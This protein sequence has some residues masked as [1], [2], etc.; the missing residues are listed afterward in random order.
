MNVSLNPSD[1]RIGIIRR[2]GIIEYSNQDN[3]NSSNQSTLG[4]INR[5]FQNTID[6]IIIPKANASSIFL[7]LNA[8]AS[9]SIEYHNQNLMAWEPFLEPLDWTI[10]FEAP[11]VTN[12]SDEPVIWNLEGIAF[13]SDHLVLNLLRND[14]DESTSATP[15]DRSAKLR[16]NFRAIN[17]NVTVSLLESLRLTIK[18]L[19]KLNS[20]NVERRSRLKERILSPVNEDDTTDL[21]MMIIRN[22]SGLMMRYWCSDVA[23]ATDI[24]PNTEK[25]LHMDI[26]GNG[27]IIKER[28]FDP[29]STSRSV[30]LSLQR[31]GGEPWPTLRD[32]PLDG[33]GCRL[34]LLEM[35]DYEGSS[36][37]PKK[38][39]IGR[40]L[41]SPSYTMLASHNSVCIAAELISRGGVRT[42][43]IRSTIRLNNSTQI[44]LH[45]QLVSGAPQR[46]ILWDAVI[47]ACSEMSVPANYCSIS[48]GRFF[49]QPLLEFAPSYSRGKRASSANSSS[50]LIPT[51]M[52]IPKIPGQVI[53]GARSDA[54]F[55][56]DQVMNESELILESQSTEEFLKNPG[57]NTLKWRRKLLQK[58]GTVDALS[59]SH[60]LIFNKHPEN[61]NGDSVARISCNVDILSQGAPRTSSTRNSDSFMLRTLTFTPPVTI[62][63]LLRSDVE[64]ALFNGHESASLINLNNNSYGFPVGT[65]V[66]PLHPGE[67]YGCVA[68]HALEKVNLSI[69]INNASKDYVWSNIVII[70]A[71][72]KDQSDDTTLAADIK[73][74]NGSVLTVLL[75][76]IDQKGH[77]VINLYVPFWIVSSSFIT[78]QY[79][80]DSRQASEKNA[81]IINGLDGLAAD[82]LF[83]EKR[84][85]KDG[86]GPLNFRKAPLRGIGKSRGVQGIVLGPELPVRGLADILVSNRPSEF[87][88]LITK[89]ADEFSVYSNVEG[90]SETY[91]SGI[92]LPSHYHLIQCSYT[93]FDRRSGRLRL[94]GSGTNWS[95]FFSLDASNST[96]VEIETSKKYA[97]PEDNNIAGRIPTNKAGAQVFCFGIFT[98]VADPPF[99]RTRVTIVV[100]RYILLNSMGQSLE[101]RQF[102]NEDVTTVHPNDQCPFWW[103]PGNQLIQIRL[104]RYGWAWS[105]RF[106]LKR[107]GEIPLRLR[108]EH[109]N[110][111]FFV[112]VHV[113][114]QG[115]R[116][117]IVF[118]GGDSVAP[119]RI[120][121]HTLETFKLRQVTKKGWRQDVNLQPKQTSL[122]PYHTCAYAWDEPLA[123]QE[124]VLELL[125]NG[126]SRSELVGTFSFNRLE[127]FPLKNNLLIR[128]IAQGPTR[129][130]CIHD[131]RIS[132]NSTITNKVEPDAVKPELFKLYMNVA[133][134]GISI[135]DRTPQE[136]VYMS[137]TD[138]SVE[139]T[140]NVGEDS[141]KMEVSRVQID[142]QILNTP[143]PSMLYPL[144]H[145][146]DE[147][148]SQKNQINGILPTLTSQLY[149]MSRNTRRPVFLSI[150]LIRNF[151][152][153]GVMFVPTLS[154]KVSPFDVNIEGVVISRLYNMVSNFMDENNVDFQVLGDT[155][156]NAIQWPKSNQISRSYSSGKQDLFSG[157]KDSLEELA[158]LSSPR[159]HFVD[160]LGVETAA[161]VIARKVLELSAPPLRL[162]QPSPKVYLQHMELSDLRLNV[163][164]SAEGINPVINSIVAS[165]D[166]MMSNA[167]STVVIAMFSTAL[168]ID[169][170]PLRFS[171]YSLDHA[172]LSVDDLGGKLGFDY[173]MQAAGQVHL[174]LGSSELLGNVVQLLQLLKEGLWDFMY[175]P[176]IGLMTSPQAF[177]SG[178]VKGFSSLLRFTAVSLCST[179]GHFAS[180][181]QIGLV[182]L[183][184]IDSDN[185]FQE[186]RG[187]PT[188]FVL[189][190]RP[191][192]GIDGL[193]QGCNDLIQLPLIG[194]RNDGLRGLITGTFK[195]SL[196]L[197]AKPMYGLLGTAYQATDRISFRLLPR[198]K[199]DQKHRLKRARPP[200][201]FHSPHLPL[202]I[203]S[204]DE[205]MGQEL[206]SRVNMGAFRSEGYIC[207]YRLR[208]GT[209]LILTTLRVMVVGDSFDF[210]ELHWECALSQFLF[211]EIDYDRTQL[212]VPDLSLIE[213]QSSKGSQ[214][215]NDSELNA[216]ISAMNNQ[217]RTAS[218]GT[219][220]NMSLQTMNV[221]DDD[222]STYINGRLKS[223]KGQP[224]LHIYFLPAVEAFSKRKAKSDFRGLKFLHQ[225]IDMPSHDQLIDLLR[226]LINRAAY[227]A[228]DD[229]EI[230][231][232]DCGLKITHG[233]Y[234]DHGAGGV[235][236]SA[237]AV[238]F[239]SHGSL[240]S[241]GNP[242]SQNPFA[243]PS[244]PKSKRGMGNLMN[245]NPSPQIF[246]I[247][248][249][250]AK[251]PSSTSI[252]IYTE[253]AK[254]TSNSSSSKI[255]SAVKLEK[256]PS[257]DEGEDPLERSFVE[258]VHFDKDSVEVGI[259]SAEETEEYIEDFDGDS[260]LGPT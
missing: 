211:L 73:F 2:N 18:S 198:V 146:E 145:E 128:L 246:Y 245:I 59:Y 106:S 42:L 159:H 93:N 80:H 129:V 199:K 187:A 97:D 257:V 188:S 133:S 83:D 58:R 30:S 207:H 13:S 44:P 153:P 130:L 195:G 225:T 48:N 194:F 5:A 148:T 154:I 221:S 251:I 123:P 41:R 43:V 143:F 191:K 109:D 66:V 171:T 68:F 1:R 101:A 120:E 165:G 55:E 223:L 10:D 69:R 161:N 241:Q 60:W 240:S 19:S 111:V 64:V 167:L 242:S 152:Y 220:S 169:N 20:E 258:D 233:V 74:P 115:P 205:N 89:K 227:L 75:D 98:T 107:E 135:I 259:I 3:D 95:N 8:C 127:T 182:T 193:K 155:N 81:K 116:I 204:A 108:N 234:E 27:N 22:D 201:F 91:S 63:N 87:G 28:S 14:I 51:E 181:L 213:N 61:K 229:V 173:A 85:S 47:P 137:I 36:N 138:I 110:T 53:S 132:M 217:R 16:A 250:K 231:I 45:I 76:I 179:I 174:I 102:G 163:S 11:L 57:N 172:F 86:R 168:K 140:T 31:P 218:I 49:V 209:I 158:N 65:N 157:R 24:P 156:T 180:S 216:L 189:Q 175:L 190:N 214:E 203:Y 144:K 252:L 208:E 12:P 105:G 56:S 254:I 255:S 96:S 134:L 136:L 212:L 39:K 222:K 17:I 176:A 9:V 237:S 94:R 90:S 235:I 147:K 84:N 67:S 21:S 121:N 46:D 117:C 7:N 40:V 112:L 119:Y 70:P 37:T 118:K 125:R 210:C 52:L 124:I 71:C 141:L 230:Y 131:H 244:S 122:L 164:F 192:G 88:K 253:T 226:H 249:I 228:T 219:A 15:V 29:L 104:A 34:F 184:V 92:D 25:P 114:K 79:Q 33:T 78:L 149:V 50:S 224:T 32:V 185:T 100:D 238:S 162:T 177:G 62:V 196:R 215:S 178:V 197:I 239:Q 4:R 23:R 126:Q 166:S 150:E 243:A 6:P 206:L 170:C 202:Q 77:R 232:K 113:I 186:E 26:E 247:P 151:T 236:S 54:S 99:Q 38:N 35:G 256:L 142:S 72:S 160:D 103:R 200:R 183:G 260:G 82:Q 139:H 248:K